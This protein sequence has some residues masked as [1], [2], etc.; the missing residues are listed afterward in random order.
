MVFFQVTP[1]VKSSAGKKQG[2]EYK[3][4]K[5][6]IVTKN[7]KYSQDL[8]IVRKISCNMLR[9][10]KATLLSS[11]KSGQVDFFVKF[12]FFPKKTFFLLFLS[13]SN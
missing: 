4:E 12:L 2:K 10:Q 9:Q 1:K 8:I 13:P 6:K 7:Y 11:R 3:V 5:F